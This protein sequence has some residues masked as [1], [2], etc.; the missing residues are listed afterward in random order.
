LTIFLAI[1]EKVELA[2]GEDAVYVEEEKFDFAG[3][4]L[5]GEFWH[6]ENSSSPGS[7]GAFSSVDSGK[8]RH[9]TARETR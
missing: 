6:P 8:A 2:V 5:R 4:G 7:E 1:R 3:A 9:T